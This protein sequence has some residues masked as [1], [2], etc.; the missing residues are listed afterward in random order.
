MRIRIIVIG[1]QYTVEK[2]DSPTKRA[3]RIFTFNTYYYCDAFF[4]PPT[5]IS[6][7]PSYHFWRYWWC[8]TFLRGL[9][10]P[11]TDSSLFSSPVRTSLVYIALDKAISFVYVSARPIIVTKATA[12]VFR[13][14]TIFLLYIYSCLFVLPRGTFFSR[15]R[16]FP[17]SPCSAYNNTKTSD[18]RRFIAGAL[19][20]RPIAVR[21]YQ[22]AFYV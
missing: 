4:S 6:S 7:L 12:V 11:G 9:M 15:R 14:C 16:R 20:I 2:C 1:V 17:K 21:F 10:R 3:Y 18:D 13:R 5:V 8:L 22:N 19:K